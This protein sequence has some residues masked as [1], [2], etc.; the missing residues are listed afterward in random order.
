MLRNFIKPSNKEISM[1][2]IQKIVCDYYGLSHDKL[3]ERNRKREIA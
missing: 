1:D 2:D 3:L